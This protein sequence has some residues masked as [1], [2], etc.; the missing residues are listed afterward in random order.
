M[1]HRMALGGR[2]KSAE[3]DEEVEEEEV[4][5]LP[6][7]AMDVSNSNAQKKRTKGVFNIVT[8][9]DGIAPR[10]IQKQIHISTLTREGGPSAASFSPADEDDEE[11]PGGGERANLPRDDASL[12]SACKRGSKGEEEEEEED[13]S[14]GPPDTCRRDSPV[15][16]TLRLVTA[17]SLILCRIQVMCTTASIADSEHATKEAAPSP[18][19]DRRS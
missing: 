15:P 13:E 12:V 5:F 1:H 19:E 9:T 11:G 7:C 16:R 17:I 8:L 14:A 18:V 6:P 4:E 10:R 3:D 2:R